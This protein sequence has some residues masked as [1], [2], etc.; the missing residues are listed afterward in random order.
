MEANSWHHIFFFF[1]VFCFFECKKCGKYYKNLIIFKRK[2]FFIVFEGLFGENIKVVD[3]TL[4]SEFM[5]SQTGKEIITVNILPNISK[6][7]SN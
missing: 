2:R 3:D 6:S 7:K 1:F 4:I 5:T